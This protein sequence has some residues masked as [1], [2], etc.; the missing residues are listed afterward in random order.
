M[1]QG[2]GGEGVAQIVE[3]DA[4]ALCV[5]QNAHELLADRVGRTRDGIVQGQ[6]EDPLG[7]ALLLPCFQDRKDCWRENDRTQ[8]RSRLWLGDRELPVGTV[9][10]A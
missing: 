1:L 2:F 4:F 6:R 3:A 5:L 7:A 8:G 10:L 9:D